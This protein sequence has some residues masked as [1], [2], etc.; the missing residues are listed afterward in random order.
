MNRISRRS[1]LRTAVGSAAAPALL[2]ASGCYDPDAAWRDVDL[3][4]SAHFPSGV[5]AGS[6][7]SDSILL[8]AEVEGWSG[9]PRLGIDLAEDP[10]LQRIVSR[11]TVELPRDPALPLRVRLRDPSLRPGTPYYYRFFSHG[12]GSGVARFTT[13]R[14]EDDARPSRLGFF[15]CQGFPAGYYTAHA[16]L[17]A[18]PNLD[19]VL[20]LG[21]YIY[22]WTDDTGPADRID[23]IGQDGFAQTLDEYRAKYR[24]YRSDPDLQA[25]QAAQSMIA[26]WDN[27][28]LGDS[29]TQR[30]PPPALTW[31]QRRA[32]GRQAFWEHMP[33]EPG[34]PERV[35]YR[36]IRVGA[37]MEI[38]LLDVHSY[39]E[40]PG[41][42]ATYLGAT[43]LAWLLDSL[44]SSRATWKIIAS[45]KVMMN[46]EVVP[47]QPI[48]LEQW[49]GYPAERRKLVEG[50]LAR[51]V[52]GVVTVTG[53]LH[54]YLAGPVTP[55]GRSGEPAG[56]VEF[57]GGSI[58]SQ[59]LFNLTP[60]SVA[61]ARGLEREARARN[62]HV[63][64]MNILDRGYG[65][66]EAGPESL[67]VVFRSP[68]TV[69]ERQSPMRDLARFRLH[70][71]SHELEASSYEDQ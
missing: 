49:D 11:S 33:M 45:P 31:A 35:L 15:S 67:S 30:K 41:P 5:V 10:L 32:N 53:D 47:G 27:H 13:L 18:E 68:M 22:E 34:P 48:N 62:P 55:S 39:A 6:P 2:H 70:L 3:A 20:S 43:Q 54:V 25:M 51:K 16:G 24:L 63:R 23:P 37:H 59:G 40:D 69:Y 42:D 1:F 29:L 64:Y 14:A 38:F 8:V 9:T 58:T 12:G 46:L 19:L 60:E 44:A 57:C 66:L 17:A 26:I 71:G 50:I 61:A 28:D 21:D 36:S 56:L 52:Q 7:T 4:R 65:V